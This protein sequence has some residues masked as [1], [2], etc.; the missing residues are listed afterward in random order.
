MMHRIKNKDDANATPH[1][2]GTSQKVRKQR[3]ETVTNQFSFFV[4]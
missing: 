4:F 1:A 3:K 2:S